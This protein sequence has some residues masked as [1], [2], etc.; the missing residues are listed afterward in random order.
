MEKLY[1]GIKVLDFSLNIAAPVATAMMADYGAD[2]IKIEKPV[3]GDDTRTVWPQV[4]G[5][6]FSAWWLNRGK[7][8]I[9]VDLKDPEGKKI[10]MD[11]IPKMDV[12][13]ESFRPGTMEKLGF[14]YEEVKKLNPSIIYV[15]VSMY[16]QNGPDSL[17]PGYDMLAQARSGMMDLTGEKGGTP[18]KSGFYIS[19]YVTS[20]YTYGGIASALFYRQ[21]TGKGQRLDISLLDATF[22]YNSNFELGALDIFPTRIGNHAAQLAPYGVFQGQGDQFVALVA[23]YPAYWA[24]LC[25]LMGREDLLSEEAFSSPAKRVQNLDGVIAAIEG[26]LKTFEDIHVPAKLMDEQGIPCSLIYN[27]REIRQDEHLKAREMIVEVDSPNYATSMGKYLARGVVVKMSETP[28]TI[29]QCPGVGEH[30]NEVLLE[31]GV[32]QEDI[33]RLQKKWTDEYYASIKK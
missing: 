27:T 9:T 5:S 29:K 26:W 32:S 14:G 7:R 3:I 18:I 28:G 19:D 16:G 11:M 4:D 1:E 17:K 10:L 13:V 8:S 6:S 24:K 12:L 20:T 15:S 23:A 22:S 33:D 21:R 30:T 31:Y 2:V 25:K